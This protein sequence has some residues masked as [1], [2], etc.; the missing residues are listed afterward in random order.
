MNA[1]HTNPL[2]VLCCRLVLWL[3]ALGGIGL[4]VGSQRLCAQSKPENGETVQVLFLG[5]FH[6]GVLIDQDKKKFMV[7]FEWGT[8]TQSKVF[9]RKDLRRQ[10]EIEAVD[11]GRTWKSVSG[12]FKI[13]A[14]M[15]SF[16]D[17][18]V[19]LIKEDLSELTVGLDKLSPADG[20]YVK[21][22]QKQLEA[23]VLGGTTP[24][25]TPE[26]PAAKSFG[27]GAMGIQTFSANQASEI[28]PLGAVPAFLTEFQQAGL[29]FNMLRKRQE[30]IAVI[31]VGGPEQLAL[32]TS[33]EDNFSNGVQRFQSQAYWVSLKTSKVVGVV[34]LTS[35]CYPLDYDPRSRRLLTLHREGRNPGQG[36]N[37][38]YALWQLEPGKSA[39]VP[40]TRWVAPDV[41]WARDLFAKIVNDKVVLAKIDSQTYQ[42]WDIEKETSIYQIKA[43]S[44]F[45]APVVLTPDR[46][47]LI[48]PEDKRVS[49][50]AAA[51]GE[52]SM[53]L[54]V[55]DNNVSGANVNADG[56]KLA[57]LTARNVYVW[58]L[59]SGDAKPTVY[60]APLM[61]SPFSSRIEWIDE[62]H[63]LGQSSSSRI[64]YRLSLQLPVWS[65]EMDVREYFLNKDPLKN[66][67]I[68]GKFFYVARPDPFDGSIALGA[69]ELP[70][71]QVAEITQNIDRDSLMIMKPGVRVSINASGTTDPSQVETWLK[72]KI[73]ENQWV[74][75]ASAA[76]VL[77]AKMGQGETQTVQYQ[78][79][80]A[81]RGQTTSASFRPHFSSLK[82]MQGDTV[83]WQGGTSTGAPPFIS[84][85]N[86]QAELNKYQTP[87]LG[88]YQNVSMDAKIIDPKY[89]RGF[90][91]SKLGLRGIEVVSTSPPGREDDP[92]QSAAQADSD[93]QKANQDR[94][95]EDATQN[96]NQNQNSD[97]NFR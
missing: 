95:D 16:T 22:F 67:V 70:G 58:D 25:I 56:T 1:A 34:H 79:F 59:S 45:D 64:L 92:N 61:G 93:Q 75:D 7:E 77:I 13:E 88:F 36:D 46:Q 33:R 71:P 49:I 84:S 76:M 23:G 96:Q 3:L 66:L 53:A 18:E 30:L 87:Q 26:L 51:T 19:T 43:S 94:Q 54:P 40:I 6:E 12:S 38:S 73:T 90:G 80:G 42:A 86:I 24:A 31:P 74:Y 78:S 17:S 50:F 97:P 55:D 89:S 68:N 60:S 37:S 65:Y 63:I 35:E 14:A 85:D 82:L 21:E 72:E 39:A 41:G 91:V 15:K 62:D 83:I 8:K 9:E 11:F 10:N 48:V 52:L 5:K 69:V 28:K 32:M 2:R 47:H 44:F 20:K 81:G 57:A 4:G 27:S 29:G